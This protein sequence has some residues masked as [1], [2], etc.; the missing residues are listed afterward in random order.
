MPVLLNDRS[1]RL[2]SIESPEF[3]MESGGGF[4]G[5]GGQF[6]ALPIAS[7]VPSSPAP[8]PTSP[9]APLF[10]FDFDLSRIGQAVARGNTQA[11]VLS[12]YELFTTGQTS[13]RAL[14]YAQS[15]V[16]RFGYPS[17]RHAAAAYL[18]AAGLPRLAQAVTPDGAG[19][20]DFFELPVPPD[21]ATSTAPRNAFEVL[22]DVLPGL[23]GQAVYNPPLQS[24]AYGFTPT[25]ISGAPAAGGG[26]SLGLWLIL[27]GVAVVA[28][29]IYKR[30][31]AQ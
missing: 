16:R 11:D 19:N 5:G 26:S 14:E 3:A 1:R 12:A 27:G 25:E 21:P 18:D 9:S 30:V 17:L 6:F 20:G 15:D 8:A 4:N 24:Q 10:D 29:F 28:Y 2:R 13:G 31:S 22:A 7:G 23:F